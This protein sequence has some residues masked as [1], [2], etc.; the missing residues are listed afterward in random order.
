M[1]SHVCQEHIMQVRRDQNRPTHFRLVFRPTEPWLKFD[2]FDASEWELTCPGVKDWINFLRGRR[3]A[4]WLPSDL[5]EF[6]FFVFGPT[7]TIQEIS[8]IGHG[9]I[10]HEYFMLQQGCK[11]PDPQEREVA[12]SR[13]H[14]LATLVT[15]IIVNFNSPLPNSD[16]QLESLFSHRLETGIP[17]VDLNASDLMGIFNKDRFVPIAV[18]EKF[19]DSFHPK[20][21]AVK[22]LAAI[23]IK[24]HQVRPLPQ[25]IQPGTTNFLEYLARMA[26]SESP[27][28][29]EEL[30]PTP[31]HRLTRV[32]I[33]HAAGIR[34]D[35]PY[36]HP[37][38]IMIALNLYQF[39][40]LKEV[41]DTPNVKGWKHPMYESLLTKLR[42]DL[43]R[44]F[45]TSGRKPL[46]D[47]LVRV[48]WRVDKWFNHLDNPKRPM[49]GTDANRQ[50]TYRLVMEGKSFHE[51]AKPLDLLLLNVPDR[52]SSLLPSPFAIPEESRPAEVKDTEPLPTKVE[53]E[54]S[55]SHET[56]R[57]GENEDEPS[58]SHTED[59]EDDKDEDMLALDPVLG[60]PVSDAHQGLLPPPKSNVRTHMKVAKSRLKGKAVL[61]DLKQ[62]A[63]EL[64]TE[65]DVKKLRRVN[66]QAELDAELGQSVEPPLPALPPWVELCRD[67]LPPSGDETEEEYPPLPDSPPVM[68]SPPASA[69]EAPLYETLANV[70]SLGGRSGE[71]ARPSGLDNLDPEI[72]NLP[73][74][75][76][77]LFLEGL[78]NQRVS[79]MTDMALKKE[80]GSEARPLPEPPSKKHKGPQ[81]TEA[82]PMLP[83]ALPTSSSTPNDATDDEQ[84]LCT[85]GEQ[86][87]QQGEELK[88]QRREANNEMLRAMTAELERPTD[89]E[90]LPI[91]TKEIAQKAQARLDDLEQQKK[92]AKNLAKKERRR[93]RKGLEKQA[94]QAEPEAAETEKPEEGEPSSSQ[95]VLTPPRLQ[96]DEKDLPEAEAMVAPSEPEHQEGEQ[97]EATPSE[98]AQEVPLPESDSEEEREGAAGPSGKKP[99]GWNR[100]KLT[101]RVRKERAAEEKREEE[102]KKARKAE[103][104]KAKAQAK[105]ARKL[106]EDKKRWEE[107]RRRREEQERLEMEREAEELARATE[108][109][110]R[111]AREDAALR[112]AEVARKEKELA[113]ARPRADV[114]TLETWRAKPVPAQPAGPATSVLP[115]PASSSAGPVPAPPP[116]PS[117]PR[118]AAAAVASPP[119]AALVPVASPARVAA[120]VSPRLP[121]VP[122][123]RS[124]VLSPVRKP[125][126]RFGDVTPEEDFAKTGESLLFSSRRP[127]ISIP[128]PTT[129]PPVLVSSPTPLAEKA[130]EPTPPPTPPP[131]PA[132]APAT[133][134]GPAF[135]QAVEDAVSARER[136]VARR[137]EAVGQRE[138][139]VWDQEK[140]LRREQKRLKQ[141]QETFRQQ[142]KALDLREV[143]IRNRETSL[144]DLFH[145]RELR[146][147]AREAEVAR[148]EKAAHERDTG[149]FHRIKQAGL[150]EEQVYRREMAVYEREQ[151]GSS[152][153]EV[154]S[155]SSSPEPDMFMSSAD[156]TWSPQRADSQTEVNMDNP[157]SRYNHRFRGSGRSRSSPPVERKNKAVHGNVDVRQAIVPSRNDEGSW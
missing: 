49:P 105:R 78:V 87:I 135:K 116:S 62:A 51:P 10:Q 65:L 30:H 110:L 107:E 70:P 16:T 108:E 112:K 122:S 58:W 93:A 149:V 36:L 9:A 80:A 139:A 39:S 121:A 101:R 63:L 35:H 134:T 66:L 21:T 57:P 31:V 28:I 146:V 90:K 8:N 92:R 144:D 100:W 79:E 115:V 136:A 114:R 83:P 113:K 95:L 27:S 143:A 132:P 20:H 72:A 138:D 59:A 124:P 74:H 44:Y 148:R 147:E 82:Q 69:A 84:I 60:M 154:A 40:R 111:Q 127:V 129:T 11:S 125:L 77:A 75:E 102:E 17:D 128:Q 118:P 6:P 155:M 68:Q 156:T 14:D 61:K 117:P 52:Q 109:S 5:P 106:A 55:C 133:K 56:P 38:G 126:L 67:A 99:P 7:K 64:M 86:A 91:S 13:L 47:E 15:W 37:A 103:A 24:C 141:Q 152:S 123:P 89:E 34:S 12:N 23:V 54:P 42:N 96:A 2:C 131:A 142:Q 3:D 119:R 46:F 85:V 32:F 19:L 145:G 33:P 94:L 76:K 140:E 151:Y 50:D 120:A 157:E 137:E 18:F 98:L 88:A 22:V 1:E 4:P 29:M 150:R 26:C 71:Q 153:F 25:Q 130:P 81:A 97:A 41:G 104:D 53:G 45:L 73:I 43:V 48:Q